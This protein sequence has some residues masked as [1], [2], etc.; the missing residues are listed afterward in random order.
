MVSSEKIS[1]DANVELKSIL[2]SL[3]ESVNEV[4]GTVES[5]K[6]EIDGKRTCQEFGGRNG[7]PRDRKGESTDD[8]TIVKDEI[9]SNDDGQQLYSEKHWSGSP[10]HLF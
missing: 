1:E 8:L 6:D 4:K 3:C 5:F 2:E 10:N 9:E 7:R